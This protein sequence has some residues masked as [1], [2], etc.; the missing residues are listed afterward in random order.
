M[1][2]LTK[3]LSQLAYPLS[4]ALLL[5][6]GAGVLL[7]RGRRR[8]GGWLLAL[9]LG[10]LWLWSTPAFSD[11][12][13][14]TLE[15][16]HPPV[17]LAQLPAADA[18]VVLGGVTE[19]AAPPLRPDPNLSAA[20]DRIWYAARLY[21]AGKAPSVL[22]SGGNLPW[23]DGAPESSVMAELLE[24]WGVPA[25]AI[26]QESA[27]RTTRENRDRSL[28]ILRARGVRRILLVTSALHMPRALALFQAT[29][30]EVMPAPTDFETRFPGNAH[31]L[32]WL[33]DAQALADG[34]RAFKE[35]LGRWV[36]RLAGF[37][38]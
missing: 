34:S 12:V 31:P 1:L 4:T 24:E 27:S 17:L 13:R 29:E 9:A 37:G 2:L 38:R 5:A 25:A 20:I 33:P 15:Q 23:S 11:W 14:A 18:I 8:S 28:P 32:R 16:R 3:V 30:L 22:V 6:V 19:A 36:D 10:W 26:V 21:R 7:W 35:Y